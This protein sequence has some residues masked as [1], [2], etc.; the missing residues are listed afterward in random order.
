MVDSTEIYEMLKNAGLTQNQKDFST[1]WCGYSLGYMG[2]M[3]SRE[4]PLNTTALLRIH[5]KLCQQ[6]RSDLASRVYE[7]I[8]E[9]VSPSNRLT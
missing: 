6:G 5:T 2:S 8:N 9:Q 1:E 4:L 3:R 7:I